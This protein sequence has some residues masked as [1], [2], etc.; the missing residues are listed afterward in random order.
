VHSILWDVATPKVASDLIHGSERP[1]PVGS[2][3]TSEIYSWASQLAAESRDPLLRS[4][5]YVWPKSL[6]GMSELLRRMKGG[7][8][9]IV[10]LQGVGKSSA[11][12]MFEATQ[13]IAQESHQVILLKWRRE[14]DLLESLLNGSHELSSIFLRNLRNLSQYPDFY[15]QN[16]NTFGIE[17]FNRGNWKS[18]LKELH[19]SVWLDILRRMTLILIDM[20]D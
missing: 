11:L 3:P 19:R 20:P 16:T 4:K 7:I 13:K 8:I 6:V 2:V 12:M 15:A 5:F 14:K 17:P 1:E 18:G 9:C 10:G